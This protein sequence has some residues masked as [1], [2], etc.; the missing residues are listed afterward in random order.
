M[1]PLAAVEQ[2]HKGARIE[3]TDVTYLQFRQA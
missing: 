3:M 2:R 1:M